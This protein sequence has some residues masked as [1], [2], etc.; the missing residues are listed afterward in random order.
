MTIMYQSFLIDVTGDNKECYANQKLVCSSGEKKKLIFVGIAPSTTENAE[1]HIYK[2]TD[3]I[4][5]IH[6]AIIDDYTHRIDFDT[7]I[8][9]G[10][11][12]V[13]SAH[14]STTQ[15]IHGVYAYEKL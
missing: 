15:T 6:H 3:R 4:G 7:E 11:Y 10:E 2:R 8:S 1:I 13:A 9:S 12:I 5:E 14:S